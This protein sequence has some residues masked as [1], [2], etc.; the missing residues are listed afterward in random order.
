MWIPAWVK[1]HLLSEREQQ[2]VENEEQRQ[3]LNSQRAVA[4]GLYAD[5]QTL[6]EQLRVLDRDAQ[7]RIV[8]LETSLDW[9]RVR[10]NQVEEERAL[11]LSEKTK[12]MFGA[13]VVRRQQDAEKEIEHHFRTMTE[14][15]AVSFDDVGDGIAAKLGLEHDAEGN[16]VRRG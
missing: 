3:T 6:Q 2:R 8:S 15:T 12:I 7:A 11:L 14:E 16:V 5:V 1:D 9:M 4:S 13:P 10:L